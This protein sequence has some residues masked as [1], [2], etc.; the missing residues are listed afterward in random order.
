MRFIKNT[1]IGIISPSNNVL[2]Y[3]PN[4][5]KTGISNLKEIGFDVVFSNN[6]YRENDYTKESVKDKILEIN[7]L[8]NQ[9]IDLLMASIGGYLSIQILKLLDYQKIKNKKITFCGSSDITALLLAIYVKTGLITL[10][11]PTYTVNMCDYGGVDEYTKNSFLDCYNHKSITYSPSNY[12]ITEYIDWND[13][14][15]KKIIKKRTS[16]R[17]DWHIIKEGNA[18]GK[19]IGGNLSTI[20]LTLGT[21]FLPENTFDNSI[22][23]L[24]DCETNINEF[25]SYIECLKLHGVLDKVK[26]IIFGKFDTNNMN[27]AIDNFVLN[28]F[29]EYNIPIVTNLDFGHVCPILTLP[30]GAKAILN[31]DNNE[32]N[33]TVEFEKNKYYGK[34]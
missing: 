13:L 8:M 27:E 29:E 21:K 33:F 32:I 5:T 24:E 17:N 30:I 14:E 16:K 19:L 18:E 22:L 12:E 6:A 20:L 34:L 2:M 11:G 31:C 9:D 25:C 3:F 15:K 23:F 26:G 7:E 1:K 28:Y 10:Y 4:R